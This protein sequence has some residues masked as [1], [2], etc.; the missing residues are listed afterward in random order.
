MTP[1]SRLLGLIF[2]TVT[3]AQLAS[4]STQ[5]TVLNLSAK[6][7]FQLAVSTNISLSTND[8]LLQLRS[9]EVFQDDGP[10]SGF[11][12]KPNEEVLSSGVEIRKRLLIHDPR[13]YKAILIVGGKGDLRI[14]VN[15]ERQ[16]LG[17]PQDIFGGQWRAYKV[18]SKAFIQGLND[19]II[20]GTGMVHIARADDSYL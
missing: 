17:I 4:A 5:A 9:G 15:G 3:L 11:S 7:I 18:D 13:N 8:S 20:Y 12:Y 16:K 2:G 10:A 6:Q 1:W 14:V 19:I